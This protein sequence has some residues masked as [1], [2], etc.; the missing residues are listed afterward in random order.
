MILVA[1][2]NY[3]ADSTLWATLSLGRPL[4]NTS[5]SLFYHSKLYILVL[6]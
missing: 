3:L 6:I 1:V 2:I 5:K 4:L